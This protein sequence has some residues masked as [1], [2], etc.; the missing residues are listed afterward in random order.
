[1][2]IN[3]AGAAENMGGSTGTV[4]GLD[5]IGIDRI[6]LGLVSDL[7][8][9]RSGRITIPTARARAVLGHEILRGINLVIAGQRMIEDRTK[10]LPPTDDVQPPRKGRK[11]K[12]P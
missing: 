2:G 5:A 4:T 9:L 6:V 7:E 8:D 12:R 11:A 3:D 10:L 1:M